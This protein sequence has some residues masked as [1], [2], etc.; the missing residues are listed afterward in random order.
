[1]D[2][3]YPN[4]PDTNIDINTETSSNN[5]I[6][7]IVLIFIFCISI[8]SS[9]GIGIYFISKTNT[10][11]NS[12]NS[13]TNSKTTNNTS[14]P[15]VK[16]ST[17]ITTSPTPPVIKTPVTTIK[18][19]ITQLDCTVNDNNKYTCT[20]P[21]TNKIITLVNGP[22][23]KISNSVEKDS[24]G[25]ETQEYYLIA[26]FVFIVDA[27]ISVS[28]K[29]I[30]INS[31]QDLLK[32]F[33]DTENRYNTENTIP[34]KCLKVSI[35]TREESKPPYNQTCIFF[36][37]LNKIDAIASTIQKSLLPYISDKILNQ[38]FT[39]IDEKI[40]SNKSLTFLEYIMYIALLN[41]IKKYNYKYY[42]LCTS[43]NQIIN[44]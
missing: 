28:L 25:K 20:D 7:V 14:S 31:L 26:P 35:K 44:C 41:H 12:S 29:E 27:I 43:D 13:I 1:M 3:D 2:I 9:I 37:G 39:T 42:T 32:F 24:F 21:S 15:A 36:P 33:D 5:Y 34:D 8:S 10:T 6:L 38:Y 22:I 4:Y 30:P 19:T 17:T 11:Q 40:K 16:I 18:G 23:F